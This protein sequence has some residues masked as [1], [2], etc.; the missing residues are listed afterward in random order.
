MKSIHSITSSNLLDPASILDMI[1]CPEILPGPNRITHSASRYTKTAFSLP[2][3]QQPGYPKLAPSS[4]HIIDSSASWMHSQVAHQTN[5]ASE[6]LY[7]QNNM[8]CLS[9]Y[10]RILMCFIYQG[11]EITCCDT[12]TKVAESSMRQDDMC[13]E[14]RLS[15]ASSCPLQA[16]PWIMGFQHDSLF[17]GVIRKIP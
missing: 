5:Q 12:A 10:L 1:T 13:P 6:V 3:G 7:C 9:H 14:N 8:T 4:V 16:R 11:A 2:T 17:T 15:P